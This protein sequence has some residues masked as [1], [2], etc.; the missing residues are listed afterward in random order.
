MNSK[1]IEKFFIEILAHE[2]EYYLLFDLDSNIYLLYID[3]IR[4]VED[5]YNKIKF[6]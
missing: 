2:K 3:R 1:K 4:S 5:M 6:S